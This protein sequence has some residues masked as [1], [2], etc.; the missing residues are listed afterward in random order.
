MAFSIKSYVENAYIG[1]YPCNYQ[2]YL[3][4]VLRRKHYGKMKKKR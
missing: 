3:N 4:A 2:S 1:L